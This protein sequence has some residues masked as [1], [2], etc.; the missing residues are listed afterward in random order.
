MMELKKVFLL[1]VSSS[2]ILFIAECHEP[3]PSPFPLPVSSISSSPD[4]APSSSS[5]VESPAPA[6]SSSAEA[7]SG[8][9][10]L[11]KSMP[12]GPRNPVLVKICGTTDHPQECLASV[13]PFQTGE[14]DPVSVLKMEMQALYQGFEK[15]FDK[16][17]EIS[18]H[19]D[20]PASI[21]MCLDTCLEMY[22]SGLIDLQDAISA[23]S[24]HD[25]D[26]LKT[27]LSAT[28]SDIDTCD[29]AFME[30]SDTH[31]PMKEI[32]DEL[33]KIASNNLAIANALLR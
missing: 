10:L 1:F 7:P 32:D 33:T 14:S 9:P 12:S 11:F 23:L 26:K 18:E 31:S 3:S 19:P 22:D 13:S 20:T 17:T 6:P 4:Q 21:K 30:E 27:V 28:L 16:A 15:A 5:D 2:L 24:N 8:L 29:E 25:I